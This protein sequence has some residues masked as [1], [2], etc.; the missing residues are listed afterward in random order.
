MHL[1]RFQ[2]KLTFVYYYRFASFIERPL[3]PLNF[4]KH[5][6]VVHLTHSGTGNCLFLTFFFIE[7][8]KWYIIPVQ[9]IKRN[10]TNNVRQRKRNQK[11]TQFRLCECELC[12]IA[13]ALRYSV[14]SF[15]RHSR[16]KHIFLIANS[17]KL[18]ERKSVRLYVSICVRLPLFVDN[19]LVFFFFLHYYYFEQYIW[20]LDIGGSIYIFYF[21][22]FV[23]HF[24]FLA[25]AYFNPFMSAKRLGLLHL[26]ERFVEK[27]NEQWFFFVAH[28]NTQC[29]GRLERRWRQVSSQDQTGAIFGDG[30]MGVM[31][32]NN[33]DRNSNTLNG[34]KRVRMQPFII[35]M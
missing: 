16:H 23:F 18:F 11:N 30:G 33:Y 28:R 34:A 10:E 7:Q 2:I 5:N 6:K 21:F 29:Q 13:V 8:H 22:R 20:L 31:I 19:K 3:V 12:S 25:H 9:R 17:K 1:T 4:K 32:R 26:C 14:D 27:D 15:L 35:C 24:S